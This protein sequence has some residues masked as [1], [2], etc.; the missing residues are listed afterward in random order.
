MKAVNF[1]SKA[2]RQL[3]S[4]RM[5]C[6]IPA[7]C[8]DDYYPNEYS[9]QVNRFAEAYANVNIFGKHFNAPVTFQEASSIKAVSRNLGV[10][11]P[12]T[13]FD[14]CDNHFTRDHG[15]YYEAMCNAVD[16]ITCNTSRMAAAIKEH[17]G[18]E[19]KV[20]PDPITFPY[21]NPHVARDKE[22]LGV[23]WFGHASN[24]QPLIPIAKKLSKSNHKLYTISNAKVFND[25]VQ[26]GLGKAEALI[27]SPSVDVV[28]IPVD[29][30]LD[31]VHCKSPNRAVDAI[32]AGRMVITNGH[33]IYED[34]KD[35]VVIVDDINEG[36]EWVKEN[37]NE[38]YTKLK[39]GQEYI[40]EKY[41]W[42]TVTEQWKT[43]IEHAE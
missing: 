20:I 30:S 26:W 29:N 6:E 14:I 33:K 24:A 1:V 15:D 5:R 38:V 2:G 10:E 41:N 28:I 35:F 32:H 18:R 11:N 21:D 12:S 7:Q 19:A 31:Y 37:P 39:H 16:K 9:A 17:T 25:T 27:L 4:H 13:I 36:I 8:L 23:L 43:V 3:A 40:L 42:K 34:L 22:S